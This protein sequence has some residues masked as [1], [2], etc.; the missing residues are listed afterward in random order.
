LGGGGSG[1][2]QVKASLGK[3][4]VRL[5]LK[6][7][8]RLVVP[9][10]P[11]M[12]EA[13]ARRIEVRGWHHAKTQDPIRKITK[14]ERA[15]GVGQKWWSGGPRPASVRSVAKPRHTKNQNLSRNCWKI[16]K[17]NRFLCRLNK[18]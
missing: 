18:H 16:N 13:I 11:A 9:V 2:F 3:K 15:E 8:V 4:L 1:E 7:E 12:R 6:K 5:H 17:I 14:E 10:I